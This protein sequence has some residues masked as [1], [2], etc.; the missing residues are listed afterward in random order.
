VGYLQSV[1][2]PLTRTPL[3]TFTPID[4]SQDLGVARTSASYSILGVDGAVDPYGT[5]PDPLSK[6]D[7]KWNFRVFTGMN[8]LSSDD[9]RDQLLRAVAHGRPTQLVYVADNGSQRLN[10]GKFLSAPITIAAIS[11]FY[12]DFTVTWELDDPIWRSPYPPNTRIYGVGVQVYGQTN[13][14]IRYG[15]TSFALATATTNYTADVTGNAIL[16]VPSAPDKA[17]I[18]SVTGPFGGANGF[19]ITNTDVSYNVAGGRLPM[20]MTISQPIPA[21]SQI[22]ID[23]G[24]KSVRLNGASAYS[25]FSY[26]DYQPEWFR[27]EPNILNHLSFA[28][29]GGGALTGGN[30]ILSFFLCWY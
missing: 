26:P 28:C 22:V 14:T 12:I 13:P 8:R 19:T 3:Y 18:L 5:A 23:C 25:L 17:P 16:G 10:T 2:D 4:I 7:F 1:R 29:N 21:G 30:A 24:A 27:L 9:A 6:H 20:S 15:D 11:Q